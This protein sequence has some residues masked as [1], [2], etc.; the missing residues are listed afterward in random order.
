MIF[1][2]TEKKFSTDNNKSQQTKNRRELVQS[3]KGYLSE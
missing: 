2:G 3:D 1:S